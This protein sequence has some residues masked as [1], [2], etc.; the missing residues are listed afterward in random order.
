MFG[1]P[2]EGMTMIQVVELVDRTI[3]SRDRLLIGVVNAAKVVNMQRDAA[4]REA[5][6]TADKIFADGMAVVWA[7]RFLGSALP[8]RVAGIDLMTRMLMLANERGYRVFCLGA[9]QDVLDETVRVIREQFP[10]AVI[11][12]SRN[13]YFDKS[14]EKVI[15]EHIRGCEPD[16]LF[17]AMTSPKKEQ[18]L[19]QWRETMCVPVCHGVGGA[20]DVMAGKVRR[21]PELW[22]KLGM[23]WLYRVVQEPRRMWRRYLVTN[24]LFSWMVLKEMFK[25]RE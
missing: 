21:A 9:K 13:G 20:F 19:A 8:E 15:A 7:S 25:G 2:I 6:L 1:M 5:V 23:E 18:F 16:M 24:S 3:A 10:R 12:G 22:Q 11:A 4:L 14:E 17:A